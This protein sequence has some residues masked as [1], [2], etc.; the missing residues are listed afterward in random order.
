M[1]AETTFPTMPQQEVLMDKSGWVY[2][3]TRDLSTLVTYPDGGWE[4][5]SE[6]AQY[7]QQTYLQMLYQNA[8]KGNWMRKLAMLSR[9]WIYKKTPW[10]AMSITQEQYEDW[11]ATGILKTQAEL[12]AAKRAKADAQQQQIAEAVA[13]ISQIKFY[14]SPDG[15]WH[16]T[17]DC[18]D[19]TNAIEVNPFDVMKIPG[20][21]SCPKCGVK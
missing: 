7:D 10:E 1:A 3:I 15:F 12:D 4:C 20:V 9:Y 5:K 2:V 13:Q 21:K 6:I 11:V 14:L 19:C 17:K 8:D 16:T 18:L